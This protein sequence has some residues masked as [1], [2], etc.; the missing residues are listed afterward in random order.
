MAVDIKTQAERLNALLQALRVP[1]QYSV[2]V[3]ASGR[4]LFK[5]KGLTTSKTMFA[6]AL[7][8]AGI[9]ALDSI[10]DNLRAYQNNFTKLERAKGE[11]IQK[12]ATVFFHQY[13]SEVHGFRAIRDSVAVLLAFSDFYIEVDPKKL[14]D[15][16]LVPVV[17]KAEPVSPV[18]IE[19][20]DD[21]ED[22][23]R[24]NLVLREKLQ[25]CRTEV[26]RCEEENTRY[27]EQ[28][29]ELPEAIVE[30]LPETQA[31]VVTQEIIETVNEL[32]SSYDTG[33]KKEAEKQQKHLHELVNELH[34]KASATTIK[35]TEDC[36]VLENRQLGGIEIKFPRKPAAEAI[37]AVKAQGF[38]WNGKSKV[39]YA[40]KTDKRM[41]FARELCSSSVENT[42]ATGSNTQSAGVIQPKSLTVHTHSLY[43]G[44]A[45]K[46]I[47]SKLREIFPGIRFSVTFDSYAGGSTIYVRTTNISKTDK[48]RVEDVVSRFG[49]HTWQS[50]GSGDP[51]SHYRKGADFVERGELHAYTVSSSLDVYVE[52]YSDTDKTSP[53]YIHHFAEIYTDTS[54]AHI[55]NRPVEPESDYRPQR[56]TQE[57]KVIHSTPNEQILLQNGIYIHQLF[58]LSLAV[59]HIRAKLEEIFP[60]VHFHVSAPDEYV[61]VTAKDISTTDAKRIRHIIGHFGRLAT[62]GPEDEERFYPG[63]PFLENGEKRR[64]DIIDAIYFHPEGISSTDKTSPEYINH[65][66]QEHPMTEPFIVNTDSEDS[67]F[68]VATEPSSE[69]DFFPAPSP[70]EKSGQEPQPEPRQKPE[71][72]HIP[73]PLPQ[74][75]TT[76]P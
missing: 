72:V 57:Y 34:E 22:T 33:D 18:P 49:G 32:K 23:R 47:K 16:P 28:Y 62:E 11:V 45:S 5:K 31:D 67:P 48:K 55:V 30:E 25:A 37:Q 71:P 38:K 42:T 20:T 53:E 64:Y 35:A 14:T 52:Q 9:V 8:K 43:G 73:D 46:K 3:S 21:C 56:E 15:S 51:F 41:E 60:R 4:L 10:A 24:E 69:E 2:T 61:R 66:S 29:R 65:S 7:R 1:G 19:I 6:Q 70:E 40:K 54:S 59:R 50:D 44:Q 68:F 36:I 76:P 13:R 26:E 63:T 75:E 12:G 39:W 17:P 27:K 74:S 58:D